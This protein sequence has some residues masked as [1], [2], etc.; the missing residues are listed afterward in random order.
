MQSAHCTFWVNIG[1]RKKG[2][3][4]FTG[5]HKGKGCGK[6]SKDN[7]AAPDCV[8]V[9]HRGCRNADGRGYAPR[10]KL[11]LPEKSGCNNAKYQACVLNDKCQFIAGKGCR[12]KDYKEGVRGRPVRSPKRSH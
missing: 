2:S 11:G 10:M 6:R 3:T 12:R 7:C 8:F 1:C 5:S 4:P 9:P